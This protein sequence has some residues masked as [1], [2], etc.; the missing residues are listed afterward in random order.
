MH[1]A[2]FELL[3]HKFSEI[4]NNDVD[5][6]HRIDESRVIQKLNLFTS[7][8]QSIQNKDTKI[9]KLK[10]DTFVAHPWTRNLQ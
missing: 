10:D 3:D 5:Y 1:T 9:K 7:T 6:Y 2:Q 4:Y 8:L